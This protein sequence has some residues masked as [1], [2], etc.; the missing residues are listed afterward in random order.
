[1]A[2]TSHG[3]KRKQQQLLGA[4]NKRKKPPLL[5]HS[6]SSVEKARALLL[7]KTSKQAQVGSNK[8]G[9]G[10]QRQSKAPVEVS[11]TTFAFYD[12]MTH[13]VVFLNNAMK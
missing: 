11:L 6:Q 2:A 13:I 4:T 5:Q 3:K 1:M 12:E 7:A 9:N 10:N 8:R